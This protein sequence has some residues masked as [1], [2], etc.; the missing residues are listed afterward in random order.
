MF[1]KAD[2]VYIFQNTLKGHK[3]LPSWLTRARTQLLPKN[4]NTH[5]AKNYRPI[6]CQN[7]MFKLYTSCIN[8]F[9]QQHCEM[10]N[11]VT[12]EQAGGKRGV[13]GCLEQLLINK[14]V[15]TEVKQNRRNL[16][17]VWLDYQKAFD[18]VPHE[19]L[20]ES[21]KL[22][23]LPPLIVTAIDTLTKSWATNIHISGE[24]VSFTSNLIEYKNGIFQGDGLSVLLFIL[25]MNPLSF[26]LN[27]LKGYRLKGN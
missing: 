4:E 5:I 6:A 19:W 12:T 21:L 8:T 13:W 26:M 27:R 2:L 9:V 22:A 7:L 14:T 17:T 3:E 20:I 11:I 15:L 18:S 16:V 25:S 1:Y 24:N 23:K 10:N